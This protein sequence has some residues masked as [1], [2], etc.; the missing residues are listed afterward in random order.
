MKIVSIVVA[1]GLAVGLAAALWSAGVE[2]QGRNGRFAPQAPSP[3]Q[4]AFKNECGACHMP[5]P[6]YMLPARSW[7]AL[8]GGLSKHFKDNASLDPDAR[9][10]I[11][12]FL[13]ANAGDAP[14]QNPRF[15]RGL[16]AQ[17]TPLRITETPFWQREHRRIDAAMLA[18][19]NVKTTANCQGCHEGAAQGDFGS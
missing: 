11:E 18:R 17:Q 6:P 12:D 5:F 15:L 13:V 3:G 10:L 14:G 19:R 2:A 1:G 7:I 4:T 8:M 9:K 16:G